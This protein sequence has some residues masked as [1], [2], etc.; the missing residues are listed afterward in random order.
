MSGAAAA[1]CEAV[2]LI[3]FGGPAAADEI[4]PFLDRV[5]KGRPVAR[6]RYEEVVR[7]YELLG[8]RSP[9][10]EFT[11]RQAA[12][13]RVA[14]DRA[15]YSVTVA[16]GMRNSPPY[17][18]D[19]LR[20]LGGCGVKRALGFI[21]AAHRCEASWDRYNEN[22]AAARTL[23]GVAAPAI[24]YPQP[25]HTHPL[26]IEAIADR[27][28]AAAARFNSA[29]RQ[30]AELIFTA[31]SIPLAM[32]GCATYS[33]QLNETARLAAQAAGFPQWSLAFQSRSGNPR[34]PWLAP[35][36]GDALRGLK[37]DAAVIIVPIGFLIDHVEVLYDLDVAA[38]QI[39][40][41]AGVTMQRAATV[42]DHPRF[43]EMM[44]AIAQTHLRPPA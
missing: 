36:I 26:F 14:L 40:R 31:H 4:R 5:L 11:R 35:D 3:G 20:D 19:A 17:I 28:G 38:A 7:H 30:R 32:S 23:V 22:V 34:E 41:E 43:I 27:I 44:A 24:D 33:A 1:N 39:A 10:N 42:G 37:R 9:Y 15:G 8:G 18:E 25:W 29:E 12:A 21:L 6:E 16:T 2:L 13:L